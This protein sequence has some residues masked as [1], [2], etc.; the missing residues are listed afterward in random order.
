MLEIKSILFAGLRAIKD[1]PASLTD[2]KK[3]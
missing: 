1:F 2:T 3:K